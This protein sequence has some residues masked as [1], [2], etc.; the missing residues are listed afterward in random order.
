MKVEGTAYIRFD[1]EVQVIL[2]EG[3]E[4]EDDEA[5]DQ[6]VEECRER[7]IEAAICAFPGA[8]KIYIDGER[9]PPTQVIFDVC[10]LD[11]E[12]VRGEED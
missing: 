6:L 10:D 4:F 9:E 8:I 7:A 1:I 2:P 11:V 5:T 12:E 3:I